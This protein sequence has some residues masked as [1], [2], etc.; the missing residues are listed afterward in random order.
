MEP[1]C[2]SIVYPKKVSTTALNVLLH[3]G[4]VNPT[5]NRFFQERDD[6]RNRLL[7]HGLCHAGDKESPQLSHSEHA[8]TWASHLSEPVFLFSD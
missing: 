2:E 8:V 3:P 4:E 6:M 5:A 7:S 1:P